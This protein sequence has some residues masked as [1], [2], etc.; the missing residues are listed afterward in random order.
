MSMIRAFW[1]SVEQLPDRAVLKVLGGTLALTALI[2][3]LAFVG[4]WYGV[5]ALSDW[6]VRTWW[7]GADAY[8]I[9]RADALIAVVLSFILGWLL[10]RAAAIAIMG[11]FA[12]GVVEAVER[13]HYPEAL[14]ACTPPGWALSLRMALFS[15][16]RAIFF[17]L[18]ALPVYIILLVTGIGTVVAAIAVNAPLLGRDLGEMVA[19]RHMDRAALRG[20]LSATRG[21]R[22]ALGLV[23]TGLFMVPGLNLLAP[24]LGAAMATHLFHMGRGATPGSVAL[25]KESETA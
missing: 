14:A 4:L 23:A 10:F 15:A 24:I 20:W 9:E 7:P 17:N 22:L 25:T 21:R 13:R 8:W 1:L 5:D 12:D 18:L 6:V 19:I 11:I 2:F 3:A 16:G